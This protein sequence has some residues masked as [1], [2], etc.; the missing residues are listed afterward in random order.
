MEVML[1]LAIGSLAVAGAASWW[2]WHS[3]QMALRAEVPTVRR[4]AD[5]WWLDM[6]GLREVE[7]ER[8]VHADHVP[9]GLEDKSCDAAAGLQGKD[10]YGDVPTSRPGDDGFIVV[11]REVLCATAEEDIDEAH[12]IDV[13][14]VGASPDISGDGDSGPETTV[15]GN[16]LD[17]DL[18]RRWT[19]RLLAGRTTGWLRHDG[20]AGE[21]GWAWSAPTT[22]SASVHTFH[23]AVWAQRG[24]GELDTIKEGH[25]L[26]GANLQTC[27]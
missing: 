11:F 19:F 14:G 23:D 24:E 5:L 26:G 10:G 9:D 21:D 6:Y 2:S 27:F 12:H 15:W 3:A 25:I 4:A 17:D 13:A 7:H 22:A 1:A 18:A 20:M 8:C 16:V